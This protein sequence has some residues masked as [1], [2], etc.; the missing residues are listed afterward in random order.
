[1]SRTRFLFAMAGALALALGDCAARAARRRPAAYP[2]RPVK[3]VVPFPPGGPLDV[4]GRTIAQKLTEAWGQSVVVDNRP[5][6][7][8]NIGAD[9]VAKSP[10]DGY[11]ILM[12][13]LSTHAVNPSLYA[14]MPYDA[15][16]DFAPITLVAVT[17]NVLVVNASLPV[18]SVKELIAY[19]K[20]NPGKLVVRLGQQRQRRAPRRRAVQGR[21]RHRHRPRPVQGR[22]AG[23]AGAARRRHAVHVRQP[24]ER[25]AA[26][27]GRQAE[28]ARRHDRRALEARA[29][30]ADDGRGGAAG[31]RHLDV[32]RPPRACRHAEGRRSPSG[33]PRSRRSSTRPRCASVSSRRARSRRR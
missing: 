2:S 26:G 33:T 22:R 9:L 28:G 10:P 20:A 32:V 1:M 11:T 21:H 23:D 13:A 24:R 15:V 17:P 30:A 19:A 29:R 16:K 5:G 3:L 31:L 7:G 18:N 27:Q 6:A 25:D 12:G 4:V 8:G 14:K